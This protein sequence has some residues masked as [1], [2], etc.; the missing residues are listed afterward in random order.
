MLVLIPAMIY[1]FATAATT[2]AV[3]FLIWCIIVGLIDNVLN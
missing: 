1:V 2:K 3:I